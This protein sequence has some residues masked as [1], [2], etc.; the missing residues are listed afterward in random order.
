M[1]RKYE[2]CGLL[3]DRLARATAWVLLAALI[4]VPSG[5]I[6]AFSHLDYRCQAVVEAK[7]KEIGVS[8]DDIRSTTVVANRSGGEAKR[9]IG[10]SAWVALQACKGSVVVDMSRFCDIRQTYTHGDCR[11]EGVKS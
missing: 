5:D 6:L 7:L 10:Y 4:W 11:L 3:R 9:L 1:P 2:E 8:P